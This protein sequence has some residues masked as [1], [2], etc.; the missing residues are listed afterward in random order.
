MLL[1]VIYLM[2]G[3]FGTFP[4]NISTASSPLVVFTI[5]KPLFTKFVEIVSLPHTMCILRN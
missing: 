1:R 2:K 5:F 4:Y 3:G